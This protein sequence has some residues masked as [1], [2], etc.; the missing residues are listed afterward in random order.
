M[1]TQNTVRIR[2]K[3]SKINLSGRFGGGLVDDRNAKYIPLFDDVLIIKERKRRM[4]GV[5]SGL[6][7][8]TDPDIPR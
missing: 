6:S 4:E 5:D 8:L 3:F 2:Y 7:T 1:V